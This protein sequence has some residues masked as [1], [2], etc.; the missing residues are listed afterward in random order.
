MKNLVSY[1][2]P[3]NCHKHKNALKVNIFNQYIISNC[4][5]LLHRLIFL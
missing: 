1:T 5:K 4:E 3:N 2:W